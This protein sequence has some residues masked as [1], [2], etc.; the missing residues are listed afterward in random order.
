M[1]GAGCGQRGWS[2][3]RSNHKTCPAGKEKIRGIR[4]CEGVYWEGGERK[5][6]HEKDI[7][8]SFKLVKH[9]LG[10]GLVVRVARL[11]SHGPEFKSSWPLN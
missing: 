11:G 1:G 8:K 2:R 4:V 10:V 7:M 3:P 5:K 6:H 9:K